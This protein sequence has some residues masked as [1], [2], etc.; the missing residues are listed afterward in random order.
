MKGTQ[1][2]NSLPDDLRGIHCKNKVVVL[3]Q[4][5]YPSCGQLEDSGYERF[6]L[7]VKT[8]CMRLMPMIMQAGNS[9]TQMY[10][11]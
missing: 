11:T 8:N 6:T 5:G 7:V 2:W 1:K 4:S 10:I 9:L 3:T